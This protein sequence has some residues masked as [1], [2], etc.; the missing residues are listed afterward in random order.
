MQK[1]YPTGVVDEYFY[2]LS[3]NLLEDRGNVSTAGAVGYSLDEYV[4]LDGRP[5]AV[6]RS[7]FNSSWVR[8]QDVTGTCTRNGEVADCDVYFPVTSS[9]TVG[10]YTTSSTS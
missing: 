3:K 1:A 4:W 5:V 10:R 2:D 6:F 7:G 8:Q 9:T